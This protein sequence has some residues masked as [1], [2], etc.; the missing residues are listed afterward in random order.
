M[1]RAS[2]FEEIEI[3]LD[4][5][6]GQPLLPGLRHQDLIPVFALRTRRHL[7]AFPQQVKSL[8]HRRGVRVAHVVKGPD[9]GRVIGDE[10]KLVPEFLRDILAE[11]PLA[12]RIEISFALGSV[13]LA[14]QN[15]QDVGHGHPGKWHLRNY[16]I[17]PKR[18]ANLRS[19]LLFDPRQRVLQPLFLERH[20][21]FMRLDP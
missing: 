12:R 6:E 10:H 14:C 8:R 16:H 4:G 9:I 21:I 5:L 7:N 11:E 3:E 17:R 20:H 2:I 15:P 18:A 1:G 13:P 19:Q